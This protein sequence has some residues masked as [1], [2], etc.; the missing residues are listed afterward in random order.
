V[1]AIV[2]VVG[3]I[4]LADFFFSVPLISNVALELQK[5]AIV[6]AAF[7]AGLGI[8]SLTLVHVSAIRKRTPMKWYFSVWLLV[9]MYST[10]IIGFISTSSSEFQWIYSTFIFPPSTTL[11]AMLAFM[12]VTATYRS[13]RARNGYALL[14]L[15]VAFAFILVDTPAI[16]YLFPT[17]IDITDWLLTVPVNASMIGIIITT[18]IGLLVIGIRTLI[19][20]ERVSLGILEE[21][22]HLEES[23]DES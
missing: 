10:M 20:R 9:L 7:A 8:I 4:M 22:P 5:W 11:Y 14:L 15:I 21:I 17:I 13:V 18:S 23:K 3:A 6:I 2:G 1:L 12:I 19:G 16:V